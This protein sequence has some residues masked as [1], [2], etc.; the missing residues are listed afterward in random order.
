MGSLVAA[1]TRKFDSYESI[2]KLT[3]AEMQ[4]ALVER[5][6]MV[7]KPD[8]TTLTSLLLKSVCGEFRLV[9]DRV[10]A[11]QVQT[12]LLGEVAN[13]L[14]QVK[15]YLGSLKDAPPSPQQPQLEEELQQLK[16][17]R[18]ELKGSHEGF[19]IVERRLSHQ[20]DATQRQQCALNA[21]LR[22]FAGKEGESPKDLQQRAVRELSSQLGV[23]VELAGAH[24]LPAKTLSRNYAAAAPPRPALLLLKFKFVEARSAVFRARAKLAGTAWGL[25]EDLT[26]LQ[27]QQRK[28]LQ[29]QFWKRTRLANDRGGRAANSSWT[30]TP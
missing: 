6:V 23:P 17:L 13:Q 16:G 24:R 19:K 18:E 10:S 1:T 21:V 27:Q 3:G 30:A 8:K 7:A 15:E 28:A 2:I 5:G 22:N 29:P 25:D 26:P 20:A 11:Q 12:N 14:A 4:Q 9:D